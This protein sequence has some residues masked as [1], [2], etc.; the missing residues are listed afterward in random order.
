MVISRNSTFTY[1]NKAADMKTIGRELG[2]RYAL[3]EA[4]ESPLAECALPAS[5]LTAILM[6]I[7]GRTD[8]KAHWR[9]YSISRPAGDACSRR[10]RAN[11]A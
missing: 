9:T 11:A 3:E 2:V 8:L 6:R 10:H 4:S 7:F 5:L 1:K